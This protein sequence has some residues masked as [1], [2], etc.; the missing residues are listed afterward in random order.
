MALLSNKSYL[1]DCLENVVKNEK[2]L[3]I[4][5]ITQRQ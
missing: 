4:N 1:L 3:D 2:K 5:H